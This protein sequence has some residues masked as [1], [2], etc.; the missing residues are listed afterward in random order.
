MKAYLNLLIDIRAEVPVVIG[1][2][3]HSSNG[4]SITS[5]LNKYRWVT[6]WEFDGKSFD[7]AKK[8]AIE[9]VSEPAFC[10]WLHK[11]FEEELKNAR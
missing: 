7:E 5:E 10:G 3:I 1:A 8:Q 2:K 4:L 6:Y 11:F 9:F